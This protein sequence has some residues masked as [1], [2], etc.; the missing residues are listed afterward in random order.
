LGLQQPLPAPLPAA[1]GNWTSV[2][3]AIGKNFIL[4]G[5]LVVAIRCDN[6]AVIVWHEQTGV[7]E[8]IEPDLARNLIRRHILGI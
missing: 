4:R 2:P 6:N 1:A 8:S 3:I 5:E 7:E